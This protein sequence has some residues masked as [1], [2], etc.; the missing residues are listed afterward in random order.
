MDRMP[1]RHAATV[2]FPP[3]NVWRRAPV[4][5]RLFMSVMV[6]R[7]TRFMP[8]N[9]SD[10]LSASASELDRL[11]RQLAFEQVYDEARAEAPSPVVQKKEDNISPVGVMALNPWGNS[12]RNSAMRQE[13]ARKR[14]EDEDIALALEADA[15]MRRQLMEDARTASIAA[16]N[17][18]ATVPDAF[19]GPEEDSG[20]ASEE[21]EASE[22]DAVD[23][24][25]VESE[26]EDEWSEE[27]EEW[28]EEDW[29]ESSVC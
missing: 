8:R 6:T 7:S 4:A 14:K 2:M 1:A 23:D 21:D 5:C 28:P 11:E 16:A 26:E 19:A 9:L 15:L 20:Q 27:D 13:L 22:E 10:A 3:V 18:L 17:K 29:P 12:D 25:Y 24:F